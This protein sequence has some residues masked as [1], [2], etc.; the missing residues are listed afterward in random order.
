MTTAI[1]RCLFG[2]P[3][4]QIYWSIA[5]HKCD[6]NPLGNDLLNDNRKEWELNDIHYFVMGKDNTELLQKMGV[7]NIHVVSDEPYLTPKP[8]IN[9]LYNKV[10][11]MKE[12]MNLFDEILYLDF[13]TLSLKDPD[14]E[15]WEIIRKQQGR[16]NGSFKAPI[17]A[18]KFDKLLSIK[19]GGYRDPQKDDFRFLINTCLVYCN[20]KNW[21]DKWLDSFVQYHDD[22]GPDITKHDEYMIIYFLDK[23][24]GVMN[25]S[26]MIET[27]DTPI[28]ITHKKINLPKDNLYFK[29]KKK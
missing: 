21:I 26:E 29:H 24:K 10:Y 18:T 13:D 28:V 17:V 23:E 20:D 6:S 1:I 9:P 11:L 3:F 8:E 16:F 25:I 22:V 27:F 7:K 12:A 15:M 2:E 14:D 5:R 19:A 4:G